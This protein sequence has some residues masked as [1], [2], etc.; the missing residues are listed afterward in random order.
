[1]NEKIDIIKKAEED[2]LKSILMDEQEHRA[3]MSKSQVVTRH[4]KNKIVTSHEFGD[5]NMIYKCK[6]N[7]RPKIVVYTCITGNYD[8]IYEPNFSFGNIDYI[9]FTDNKIYTKKWK[10]KSIPKKCKQ[11]SA[12]LTNRFLKMHPYRLFGDRYDYAIY[13]DGNIKIVG[14]LNPLVYDIG[15]LGLAMHRHALRDDIRKEVR[16]CI[17]QRKGSATKLIKQLN[18]YKKEGFPKNYGMVECNMIVSD[19]KN[20]VARKIFDAWWKEFL[21]SGSGRDQIALPYVLWDMGY[22]ISDLGNLGYNIYRNPKVRK[23]EHKI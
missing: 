15:K 3:K 20:E 11:V 12:A 1:M 19:L 22:N 10:I 14:D 23:M 18:K 8:N 2:N 17:A 21:R 13:V 4:I 5:N 16:S 6:R 7:F 9:L